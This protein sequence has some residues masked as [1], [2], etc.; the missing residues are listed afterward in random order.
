ML[1]YSPTKTDQ[2]PH[3]HN[4]L[5]VHHGQKWFRRII[6]ASEILLHVYTGFYMWPPSS[7]ILVVPHNRQSVGTWW[8]PNTLVDVVA[9]NATY[10]ELLELHVRVL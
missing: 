7:T 10:S 5:Q 1:R 2:S 4:L 6:L 9:T 8:P 3:V